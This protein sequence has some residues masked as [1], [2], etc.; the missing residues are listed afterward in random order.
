MFYVFFVKLFHASPMGG[1]L[2]KIKLVNSYF[3]EMY[4]IILF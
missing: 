4:I 2:G 1:I 3:C